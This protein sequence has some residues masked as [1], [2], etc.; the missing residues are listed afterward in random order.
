[1]CGKEEGERG[2]WAGLGW[3]SKEGEGRWNIESGRVSLDGGGELEAGYGSGSL[4]SRWPVD[5]LN[6]SRSQHDSV[7]VNRGRNNG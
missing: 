3:S 1:M 7:Q 6:G 2:R 4:S 5:R